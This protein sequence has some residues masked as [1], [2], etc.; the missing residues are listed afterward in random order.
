VTVW[1]DY[2][3]FISCLFLGGNNC[4]F[5]FIRVFQGV[6][7]SSAVIGSAPSSQ[8]GRF[9]GT[10]VPDPL[11]ALGAMHVQFWTDASITNTG[12]SAVVF[13]QG[14]KVFALIGCVFFVF[15]LS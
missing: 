9:C 1:T 4:P 15:F 13:I 5:D 14:R 12:F 3:V 11:I 2:T 8:L 7:R 10:S 6:N